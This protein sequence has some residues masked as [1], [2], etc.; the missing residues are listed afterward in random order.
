MLL[1][2]LERRITRRRTSWRG[3]EGGVSTEVQSHCFYS[4]VNEAASC[5]HY[6]PAITEITDPEFTG[7]QKVYGNLIL[8]SDT[9]LQFWGRFVMIQADREF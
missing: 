1:I 3:I 7:P 6:K 8:P 5:V 2:I 4:H 9:D